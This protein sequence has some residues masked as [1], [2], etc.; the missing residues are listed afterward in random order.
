MPQSPKTGI[1]I[2][3]IDLAT[4]A[5]EAQPSPQTSA[6]GLERLRDRLSAAAI[7]LTWGVDC[8]Q[9]AVGRYLLARPLLSE[10]ALLADGSWAAA[11][12]Q[13]R[14]FAAGLLDGLNAFRSAGLSPTTLLLPSLPTAS[15]D[16]L[17][18]KHGIQMVRVEAAAA[19]QRDVRRQR[20]PSSGASAGAWRSLRW[21][22]REAPITVRIAA[23]S[24]RAVDRALGHLRRQVG[25]AVLAAHA[26]LLCENER[27]LNRLIAQLTGAREAGVRLATFATVL[28]SL[29]ATPRPS[30][31]RSILHSAA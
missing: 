21:G 12:V 24:E 28:E 11:G 27:L 31:A 18:V 29:R 16:D 13:R 26:G 22:L 30:C 8:L 25:T 1:C 14:R 7:P 19:C 4:A 23:N 3:T 10:V 20:P 9:A 2:L 15:H 5:R 17:L 6:T